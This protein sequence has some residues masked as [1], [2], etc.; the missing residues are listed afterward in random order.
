MTVTTRSRIAAHLASLCVY[1]A[2]AGASAGEAVD[3]LPWQKPY[4]GEAATGENVIALWQF[5]PGAELKDLSGHGHDLTL[6]GRTRFVEDGRFGPCLESFPADKDNDKPQGAS[7][8]NDPALSP[9]GPFTLEMWFRPKPEMDDF[10]TVFLV[11]KKYYHY[12]KDLPQANWDYCLYLQRTGPN[13]RQ[14]VAYLGYGKD[15]MAY[16]S[17]PV[18]MEPG[19]WRHVAFTYDGAGTGRFFLDGKPV[20]RATHEGRG[21]IAPGNYDLVI[22]DRYGSIHQ[23]F[24][25]CIDEIRISKGVVPFFSGSL[26]LD[27]SGQRMAFVR[28]EKDARISVGVMNDTG[29]PLS[30]GKVRAVFGDREKEFPLPSLA[31]GQTCVV[32]VPIDSTLRPGSYTLRVSA[33]A[34]DGGKSHRVEKELPVTIAPRPLPHRMPVVMWGGGDFETLK[35]IGFTHELVHLADFGKIWAAGKPTEAMTSGAVAEAAESLDRHLAEGIGAVAT[36]SPGSW[37][38]DNAE[39]KERFQRVDRA[40]KPYTTAN[41]CGRFPEVQAFTYNVGAS[42]AQTFG[43]FPALQAALIHTEVRD[44]TRLCFHQRDRDAFRQS[45]GYDIPDAA[46][47]NWGVNYSKIEGFPENRIVADNHPILTFYRWFWKDGD[48]WNPLHTQVHKGLKSTGREDLW[49][50]FDPAVRVPSVWG[51]GGGVDVLSQ[52]TY[53]YPDPI[54]IGQATD[55][56]FAMADGGRQG[57]KVMKMTQIIWYRSQTSPK[58]PEDE[59]KRV[60][61]EEEIPDAKFI[62]IAPDHLREAFWSKIS[63]PIQGIMYHGWGSLVRAEHGGYRFTNPHTREALT[64]LIHGVVEPLGPTLV[65]IPD[66]KSDVAIL[67]SF[68]SQVFAGRGTHGWSHRWEADMHLLLQWAHLQP[69]VVYDETVVRDGLGDFRV[70]VLPYGDVLTESVAR[71]VGEFQKKGGILVADEKLAPA[72]KPDILIESRERSGKADEDKAALQAKAAALRRELNPRYKRHG[73]SSNPDVVVRFRQYG[74]TDY[75]FAVNDKRTFGDYVGHHGKVMEKGLPDS[76][77]LSVAREGGHVYD[78]VAHKAIDATTSP[79]GLKFKADFGPGEG[80]VFMIAARAI[81]DVRLDVPVQASLGGRLNVQVSVVDAAGEPLEAVVPL[82]V[83]ILDPQ[84]RP[85]ERTGHYGAKDG[86]LTIDADLAPNDLPGQ[87]TIRVK[88]LASGRSCEKQLTVAPAAGRW[89][90]EKANAWRSERGWLVGCNFIPSTAVNQ[91]EMF[92]ADTFD[93]PTIDRELGWAESLG[94]NSVR[95]YLQ[96]LLREQDPKGFLDRLDKFLAAADKHK[97]GVVFVLFDS[98]WDPA[99]KLGRQREPKPHVHNSGWVQSPGAEVLKDPSKHDSLRSYVVGVVGRFAKD[100]RVHA[101]D[102]WNEPDNMNRPAY[103][104]AEPPNKAQLVLPLLEKAFAWAREAEPTQPLTSGVWM[105]HWDDPAKLGPIERLQLDQSDVVSFH[106]YSG[107]DSLKQSIESLRRYRRPLLC[108][109]YMSRGNASKFDSHLGYMK[110]QGVA[111]YNWGLVAGKT[112]TIYPW[113]SWSK[114]Y[115]AEPP[116]WFHD[117]FRG[118]GTPYDAS[119]ADYIRRV[120]GGN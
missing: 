58:L 83:E 74:G 75:L 2:I 37:V 95:V 68:A 6:R 36:L 35:A 18:E 105:G 28:M 7:A 31:A 12:A 52:W 40:G 63:R 23:G 62:T 106:N 16:T 76:A 66:R 45:A 114:Q 107:L 100:R 92:Q 108:T 46:A 4:A 10:A 79:E 61:W 104:D 5:N 19:K 55:E 88:E 101:W 15:S 98:C 87:W 73:D 8:K 41:T 120:T 116:L 81:A 112:Q 91:L 59:S 109:E 14:I 26:E 56:L 94:F 82:H 64:E 43:R 71:A 44:G 3:E 34:A 50:F 51:S 1:C 27:F 77:E 111:A 60:A 113:D 117:I 47:S 119:E 20:G 21:P 30:G 54:K 70:L 97:I 25:G 42:V 48:G 53:S 32:E 93:L 39:L 38:V 102:V 65:Q 110:E 9:Q 49:T 78:L 84:G 13:R 89:S 11:D 57:Q 67:E 22:G 72:L 17:Q 85:A 99:P 69:R 29:K 118:D 24:P 86:R 96:N 80:R 90:E 103:V 115:T 33:S